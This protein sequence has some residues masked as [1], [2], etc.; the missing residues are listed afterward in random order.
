MA[1]SSAPIPVA[2]VLRVTPNASAP[3]FYIVTVQ[4]PH[5]SREHTHGAPDH[6]GHDGHRV[7]HCADPRPV[8]FEAGY[9]LGSKP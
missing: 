7:A 9:F 5:C 1:D 8:G 2:T 3:G 6:T 4:C